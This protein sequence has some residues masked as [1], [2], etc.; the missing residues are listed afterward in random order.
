MLKRNRDIR[1]NASGDHKKTSKRTISALSATS[2]KRRR[3][4]EKKGVNLLTDPRKSISGVAEHTASLLSSNQK[5]R[6]K[7]SNDGPF[8]S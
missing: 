3:G 6:H 7:H 1:S 4:S 5:G 2:F 8:S